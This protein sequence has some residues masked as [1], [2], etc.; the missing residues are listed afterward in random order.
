MKISHL[1]SQSTL[2][3]ACSLPLSA[4]VY[5]DPGAST[6]TRVNDL[7]ARMTLDEKIGQM[8]QAERSAVTGNSQIRDLFLGSIL[9]GGGSAPAENSPTGWADLYD[10]LQSSALQTRLKIPI[11]YGIDAV[12]GHNNVYG[13]VIFPHNIGLGATWN[14]TLVRE[15]Q[16]ITA[17]EV[18]GTGIDWTFSPCIAVPRDER[19][20]RTYEGFGETPDL[21][22][23]MARAA[24][25]GLQGDSLGDPS[26][27]AACSKHYI[28]DGGTT[29][30]RDQGN[31][32][33][34]EAEL[35]AIHLPGYIEAIDAGV[36]TV[37]ASFNSWNGQKL[38]GHKYLLTDVLK[39]ELAFKGFVV[40]DWEGIQQLPGD[41]SQDVKQAI[42]AGIDMVMAPSSYENFI[43]TLRNLVNSGEVPITRI[44]DAVS[45][46]LSVKFD[47]GL[48]EQPFT[49]RALTDSIG[50]QRHRDIARQ[51]VRESLVLL[52]KE[53]GLLPLDANTGRILVAGSHA[54]NLGYQC[55]GW[56]ISWQGSGGNTT[57]GTTILEALQERVTGAEIIY[58]IY[59]E[60]QVEADVALVVI[61]EGPYAEGGGD[62]SDLH[63]EKASTQMLRRIKARGI[64]TVVLL[65]TGRPMVVDNLLHDSDVLIAGWLPGTEGAGVSDIL[66]G[67]FEP[68]GKLSHTWPR[69]M[70]QIPINWGDTSYDPLFTYQHGIQTSSDFGPE[71]PMKFQ[72]AQLKLSGDSLEIALDRSIDQSSTLDGFQ[73]HA[74]ISEIS[75]SKTVPN[76][77]DSH[78]LILI[79][80]EEP[81]TSEEI[82]IS[83]SPGGV[84]GTDGSILSAFN[85]E[86]VYDLR[87]EGGL[88]K[89]PGRIEAED[90]VNSLGVQVE[91]TSDVGGGMN[92]GWIDAGDWIGYNL[93][94]DVSGQYD[95][96]LRV[97]A[98]SQTGL[99]EISSGDTSHTIQ[100]EI[101]I[102]YGWQVWT[103]ISTE[104]VLEEGEQTLT[105]FIKEGGFNLNWMDFELGLATSEETQTPAFF[106]LYAMYPNPFNGELKISYVLPFPGFVTMKVFNMLGRE[107]AILY[108]GDQDTGE[109]LVTW[110]ADTY[111][112]STYFVQVEFAGAI[113][114]KKCILLK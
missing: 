78:N 104:M 28:G 56:T 101:P 48:F 63:L 34:S 75:I 102:T 64:P 17:L 47:L 89:V 112:S 106:N 62:D 94:V 67:D 29:A 53:N 35:R 26:S 57:I 52:K 14:P 44:D 108:S 4:Q 50:I 58:D 41:F 61:G 73:V 5:L 33:I 1:I 68:S 65:L 110:N 82:K 21:T 15:T 51:A 3:L 60:N 85:E 23:M 80:A 16:R 19:W 83:Y 37:M 49:N 84:I 43:N 55:G 69:S 96:T 95:V 10:A 79:L 18:A 81:P 27:I 45:R 32:E 111:P 107:I 42:M 87:S 97:A 98:N 11:I 77:H 88:L 100:V 103:S 86:A 20:G 66:F 59:D 38:H 90:F 71:I 91:S 7:L 76:N 70:S 74:G 93:D 25:E 113:T 2:I 36:A 8:T 72:S 40:S 92:V 24:V 105:L 12:H 9:S 13:A 114:T 22:R 39:D 31:T 54:N 46:I 99:A 109:H 6:E 30:G